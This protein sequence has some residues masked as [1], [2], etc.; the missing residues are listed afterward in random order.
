MS[1]R[2]A[3]PQDE[4]FYQDFNALVGKHA[5]HLSALEMLAIAANMVGK[6]VAMQDQRRVTPELAMKTVAENIR[7][8]NQQT[9]NEMSKSVGCA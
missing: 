9:V 6:L 4:A 3:K 2:A 8:G 5:A 7:F 1:S